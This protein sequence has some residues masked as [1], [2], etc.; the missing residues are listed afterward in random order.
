[1]TPAGNDIWGDGVKPIIEKTPDGKFDL[2]IVEEKA[3]SWSENGGSMKEWVSEI[4]ELFVFGRGRERAR[5]G[6]GREWDTKEK[7]ER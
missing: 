4:E 5:K 3:L 2:K 6:L 7:R 1:M